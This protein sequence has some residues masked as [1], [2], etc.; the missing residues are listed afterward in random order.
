MLLCREG[1]NT[2]VVTGTSLSQQDY[3]KKDTHHGNNGSCGCGVPWPPP[4]A[5][6][7][8]KRE[9]IYVLLLEVFR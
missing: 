6:I 7:L 2:I 3:R 4:I 5:I 8:G 9:S 1:G